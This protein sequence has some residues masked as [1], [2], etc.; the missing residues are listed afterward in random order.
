MAR[1]D[2]A[3]REILTDHIRTRTST[4]FVQSRI[5]VLHAWS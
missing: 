1:D 2:V 3:D 4:K 5:G